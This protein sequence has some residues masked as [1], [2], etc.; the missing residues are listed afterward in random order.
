M[1]LWAEE[2]KSGT[3]ELLLTLPVTVEKPLLENFWLLGFYRFNLLCTFPIVL[4]VAYLGEPD[5]LVILIGYLLFSGS[6]RH[7]LLFS[8]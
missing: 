5:Y 4:T 7:W 1:R 3:I 2:R 6:I 8:L